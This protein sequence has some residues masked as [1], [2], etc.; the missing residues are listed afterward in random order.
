MSFFGLKSVQFYDTRGVGGGGGGHTD[1]ESTS[2]E[3]TG[4]TS[5][6]CFLVPLV[7]VPCSTTLEIL[8]GS[9]L[10]LRSVDRFFEPSVGLGV[11]MYLNDLRRTPQLKL[12][13]N[14]C[15]SS[16]PSQK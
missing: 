9:R 12:R 16:S 5:V 6:L 13:A 15:N 11:Y 10:G 4:P 8:L 3:S 7:L 2:V 14:S 1:L